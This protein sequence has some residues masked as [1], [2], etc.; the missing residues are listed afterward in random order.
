[1]ELLSFPKIVKKE[2][3]IIRDFIS[4]MEVL[5]F[6]ERIKN[7]AIEIRRDKKLKLLDALILSTSIIHKIPLITA[8]SDFM[9]IGFGD[10]ILYEK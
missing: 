6:D 2:E 8:D 9:N 4:Q 1:M 7:K 3:D 10:I 5:S